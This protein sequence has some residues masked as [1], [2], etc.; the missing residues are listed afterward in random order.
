MCYDAQCFS[1][2]AN[3]VL[4][5]LG[6]TKYNS[7]ILKELLDGSSSINPIF[8]KNRISLIKKYNH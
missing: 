1:C 6:Q 7:L 4:L 3:S 8:G 5:H 2:G